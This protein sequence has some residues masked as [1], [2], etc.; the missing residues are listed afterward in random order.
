MTEELVRLQGLQKLDLEIQGL[1]AELTRIPKEIEAHSLELRRIKERVEAERRRLTQLKKES[2]LLEVDLQAVDEKIRSYSTQLFSARTNEQY[3]AFLNE[4]DLQKQRKAKFEERIIEVMEEI[5][6]LEKEIRSEEARLAHTEV[7]TGEAVS[8]LRTELKRLEEVLKE[9]ERQ[10][11]EIASSLKPEP[12]EIYER[13]RQGK[14]GI[15]VVGISG[16]RCGGCLN[17][18]PPQLLIEIGKGDRLYFCEYCGRILIT[19]KVR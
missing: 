15:A 1:T 13:I 3:K 19:E 18:L 2:H 7:E 14:A 8:G 11:A 9:A 12:L 6:R 17:P 16:D 10:R 4:I 5:E